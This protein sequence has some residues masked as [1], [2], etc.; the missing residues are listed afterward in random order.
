MR[1]ER[2]QWKSGLGWS[3]G[4][5]EPLAG[6]AQVVFVF[7]SGVLLKDAARIKDIREMYPRALRVGCSTGGE[8]FDVNV[9]DETL[10]ASALALDRGRVVPYMVPVPSPAESRRAGEALAAGLPPEGLVHVVVLSDGLHVNGSDLVRGLNSGL[11]MGVKVTGGLSGDGDRFLETGVLLGDDFHSRAVVAIGFYGDRLRVGFG[12]L[13]GWDTF[14][15]RRLITKSNGNVL[16][17]LDGKSALEI[18]KNYLGDYAAGLPAT[19]LLF[20]LAIQRPGDPEVLVRSVLAVDEKKGTMTFAGDMP[21]GCQAQFM[22][23]NFD[24][25]VDGAEGAAGHAKTGFGS[26]DTEWALLISCVGR[27]WILKQ[28]VEEEVE[29]VRDVL[30]PRP[31]LV[32]FYSYG[33]I[34]P[35]RPEARCDLHNQTMTV[36][37]F[38]EIP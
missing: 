23:A 15:P 33:E 30:G 17:S 22:M 2:R 21:E 10:V 14:G 35:F 5:T 36:T 6:D 11:P 9:S 25:M 27:K 16:E 8:I 12:S 19:G 24:R 18:Y 1:V 3:V 32:G 34:A 20:P 29:A 31:V 28:R 37:T 13:G 7:G 4:S 26:S 38:T